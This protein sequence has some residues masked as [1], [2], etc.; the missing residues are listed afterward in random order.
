[1]S[2][3]LKGIIISNAMSLETLSV[4]YKSNVE[5]YA[6]ETGRDSARRKI[7]ILYIYISL[8]SNRNRTA[9]L[10]PNISRTSSA[11]GKNYLIFY[12]G[13]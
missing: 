11:G 13:G 4:L 7:P 5:I 2:G 8:T 1:M 3:V 10:K 6:I 9:K 12:Y